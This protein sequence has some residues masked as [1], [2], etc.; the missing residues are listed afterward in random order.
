MTSPARTLHLNID[1]GEGCT[2]DME[3]L[4]YATAIN[5]A[6]G[7]HAGDAQTMRQLAAAAIE[8]GIEIGAHPSYPDRENFGR[9]SMELPYDEL[10]AGIQY[11][12]SAL[13]GIVKA[14]GG[15]LTHVKPHGALYNDAERNV[16]IAGAIVHSVRDLDSSL[17]IIG[18]SGGQLVD[19]ARRAGLKAVDEAFADRRYL[20]GGALMPRSKRGSLIEHSDLVARQAMEILTN[21]RAEAECGAW[22]P[23]VSQTLCLHGD[24]LFA[25]DCAKAIVWS[26]A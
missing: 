13:A 6:C 14:L 22:I 3:L 25:V 24:S 1:L 4:E 11:Q 8:R 12:V 17:R 23:I 2:N 16:E 21:G 19:V 10:Y 9:R 5:I 7:W 20:D 15:R 18:L 26:R